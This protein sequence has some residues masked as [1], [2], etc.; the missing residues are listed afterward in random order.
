M[1][2]LRA[3]RLSSNW[4]G[5][6]LYREATPACSDYFK[7]ILIRLRAFAKKDSVPIVVSNALNIRFLRI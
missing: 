2:D 3:S 4:P 7:I 6:A 5:A 1:S